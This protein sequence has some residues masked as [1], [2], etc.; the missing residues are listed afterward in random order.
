[1]L[2]RALLCTALHA[3]LPLSQIRHVIMKVPPELTPAMI[4]KQEERARKK[5]MKQ[6]PE[7]KAAAA[8]AAAAEVEIKRAQRRQRDAQDAEVLQSWSV[9]DTDGYCCDLVDIGANLVKLKGAGSLEQQLQ[10]CSLAGVTSVLVTGTSVSGSQRAMELAASATT[11]E[12]RLYSTAGVHPHDAKSCDE[13]TISALR[14]ILRAPEVVA[15]G[16]CGLD[17]DRMFSPRDVQLHWFEQQARLAV[18]VDMPLFLHQ[19]DLD[20]SKGAPI[21]SQADLLRILEASGVQ[22]H[23]ACV[24]CFTGSAR[25]LRAYV[26]RGYRIGLTGFIA[27]AARGAHVREAIRAGDLPLS[28][29]MLETD[30]PFMK[31]DKAHL[32]AVGAL[33]RGQC[34]PCM[35]P[36][37]CRV[38][39]ECLDLAPQEVARATTANSRSFFRL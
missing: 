23:R 39:A 29:L 38:V 34:E 36:A 2:V 26:E 7:F 4:A 11:P 14:E 25:E 20:G 12:V 8:A 5:S 35:V 13:T 16:E 9:R 10:R 18:E 33:K 3:P 28:S 19:R 22:P 27:M 17:Y 37:V 21:G 30:A 32:P 6:T 15:V 24:H 1:M 31:P